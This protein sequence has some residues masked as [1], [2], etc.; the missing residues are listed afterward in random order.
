[1]LAPQFIESA[2]RSVYASDKIS[3]LKFDPYAKIDAKV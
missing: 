2:L 3:D 1:M